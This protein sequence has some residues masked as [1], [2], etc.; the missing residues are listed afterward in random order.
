MVA[1]QSMKML[2][3]G[4]DQQRNIRVITTVDWKV[5]DRDLRNCMRAR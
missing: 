1:M 3:D 2:V 4:V 5:R